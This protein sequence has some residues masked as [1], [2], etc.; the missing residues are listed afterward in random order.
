MGP[1]IRLSRRRAHLLEVK[2]QAAARVKAKILP[3]LRSQ[4]KRLE[5][6]LRRSNLRKRLTKIHAPA[7]MENAQDAAL[8]KVQELMKAPSPPKSDKSEWDTWKKALLLALL[9]G[10]Y[11]G[12]D[13]IGAAENEV[14]VSRGH[15]DLTFSPD[16]V[17]QDYQLRNG[18]TL[19]Q[20]GDGT[21][22]AVQ[23]AISSWYMGEAPFPDLL[24]ELDRLFSDARAEAI[25]QTEIGN[26]T[27]QI[28]MQEMISHGW[29]EWI[30]DAM[31]EDPCQQLLVIQGVAYDGCLDLNGRKFKIGHPMPPDAAHPNCI[32]PGQ[33]VVVPNLSGGIK[34]F[35]HG[36]VIELTTEKGR[37]LTI[38]PN[39]PILSSFGCWKPAHLFRKGDYLVTHLD[40]QRM[41]SSVYPYNHAGP[42]LVEQ[43]FESL[44]MTNGMTAT[45]MPSAPEYLHGDARFV[46]GD[47]DVINPDI[48][49]RETMDAALNQ[50]VK[51]Q[52]LG[53]IDKPFFIYRGGGLDSL[54]N[55][56]LLA[57]NGAVGRFGPNQALLACGLRVPES[58]DFTKGSLLDVVLPQDP[59]NND[60]TDA[61]SVSEFVFRNAAFIETDEIVEIRGSE[62]SGHV[63]D[64]SSDFYELYTCNGIIVHNCQCIPTPA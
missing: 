9:L 12:V 2:Q 19:D 3:V 31:G 23:Q 63:Y 14:W 57:S 15:Q 54:F 33:E 18:R 50:S 60:P 45:R 16:Q 1:R 37:Q 61:I 10:L 35:Y 7:G 17:V 6:F 5:R 48:Q 34:S 52:F 24:A 27:S 44:K 53:G 20:I 26:V 8:F 55:S 59:G 25:A 38:T 30:W 64:L 58:L 29:S 4:Y 36:T 51:Y 56:P 49:L 46:N 32:I 28:F 43:V 21:L 41:L 40:P 42:A 11:D 22:I 47:I 62:F 13:D 39:H